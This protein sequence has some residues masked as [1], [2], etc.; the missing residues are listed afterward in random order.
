[1]NE[2]Q[3]TQA[4]KSEVPNVQGQPDRDIVLRPAVDVYEDGTGIT[5]LADLPGVSRD[6]LNIQVDKNNLTIEGQMVI[7]MP[8]GMESLYAEV[9]GSRFQRSFSLSS[10]LEVD[11]I[12]AQ[13][14]DGVLTLKVP[15]RSE[16]Q[17]RKIEIKAG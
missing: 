17:P 2:S 4:G 3:L 8:E 13:M 1:M 9:R 12:E 16:L 10:E 11:K 6:R 7:D 14:K 15:K 5:L